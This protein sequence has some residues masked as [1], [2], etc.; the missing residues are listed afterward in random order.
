[1][2]RARAIVKIVRGNIKGR[3]LV[4]AVHPKRGVVGEFTFDE[5]GKSTLTDWREVAP[6]FRRRKIGERILREMEN[7]WR[8]NHVEV[9][10]I[11]TAR[12]SMAQMLMKNGYV[13]KT[14]AKV[15]I[16]KKDKKDRIY[17]LNENG[18]PVIEGEPVVFCKKIL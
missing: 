10:E 3:S 5:K 11:E 1:M 14:G 7:T 8:E 18:L 17:T 13:L 15:V 16:F 12:A 6:V 4:S 2:G 9:A